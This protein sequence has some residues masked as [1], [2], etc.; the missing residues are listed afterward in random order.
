MSRSSFQSI[1][2]AAAKV[3]AKAGAG[4]YL[5]IDCGGKKLSAAAKRCPSCIDALQRARKTAHRLRDAADRPSRREKA[6]RPAGCPQ[7]SRSAPLK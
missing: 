2:T 3:I 1:A 7:G 6:R 4:G 5:C